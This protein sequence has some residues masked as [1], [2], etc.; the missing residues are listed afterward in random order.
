[1]HELGADVK[2]LM[3][4]LFDES[5]VFTDPETNTHSIGK[6]S[7]TQVIMHGRDNEGIVHRG[8]VVEK[9]SVLVNDA[10]WRVFASNGQ[11]L[12]EE[13]HG[14]LIDRQVVASFASWQI[15]DLDL[16]LPSRLNE[17]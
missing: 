5:A 17:V 14:E 11:S 13:A 2:A 8:F 1:L 9:V 15:S 6:T 10:L 12:L 3:Q 7:P 16:L 4:K